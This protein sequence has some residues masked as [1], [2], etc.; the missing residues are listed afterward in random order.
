A[1]QPFEPRGH[2][3]V[4][5]H[6]H[7]VGVHEDDGTH[8][9]ERPRCFV[10]LQQPLYGTSYDAA[11]AVE[12]EEGYDA[13]EWR[14]CGRQNGYAT[15]QAA[16]RELQAAEQECQRESD[17]R[18]ENHGQHGDPEAGDESFAVGGA[19]GEC[20]PVIEASF[21]AA[22]NDGDVGKNDAPEQYGKDG[23]RYPHHASIAPRSAH[24]A[25]TPTIPEPW[26]PAR[27]QPSP[28]RSPPPQRLRPSSLPPPPRHPPVPHDTR[29]SRPQNVAR[30]PCPAIPQQNLPARTPVIPDA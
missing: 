12:E 10:Q 16:T 25:D 1:V 2:E 8:A 19:V 13:H 15:E 27:D 18:G 4:N 29:L 28:P 5:V 23:N 22:G 14:E 6:I 20:A 9:G 24:L 30:A 11:L 3:Q 21:E 26:Q 7:R 17:E